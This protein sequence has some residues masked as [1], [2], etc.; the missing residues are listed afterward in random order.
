M[1]G[2]GLTRRSTRMWVQVAFVVVALA[3]SWA[4][5]VDNPLGDDWEGR[6]L[7]RFALQTHNFWSDGAVASSFATSLDPYRPGFNYAHHPPLTNGLMTVATGV[8]GVGPWQ[9]RLVP[10]LAAA[11]S[12]ILLAAVLRR[13]AVRE[14]LVGPTVLFVAALPLFWSF[15]RAGL[16][17]APL[18]A[19]VWLLALPPEAQRRWSG[20][21]ALVGVLAS[22]AGALSVLGAMIVM[23]RARSPAFRALAIGAF[24]GAAITA[25]WILNATSMTELLGHAATRTLGGVF[26][27]SDF[28]RQQLAFTVGGMTVIGLLVAIPATAYAFART[29]AREPLLIITVAATIVLTAL[30]QAAFSRSFLALPFVAVFGI[31]VGVSAEAI[32]RRVDGRAR[33]LGGVLTLAS[34]MMFFTFILTAR[35]YTLSA[36]ASDAGFLLEDV[37]KPPDVELLYIDEAIIAPRWAAWLWDVEVAAPD[38][39]PHEGAVILTS[40]AER[41]P[42]IGEAVVIAVRGD[43]L[44]LRVGH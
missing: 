16:G 38:G 35:P 33:L 21:I 25:I 28:T 10:M 24:M 34:V 13:F 18:L 14:T 43:Y 6:L 36:E 20:P 9:L 4:P 32:A 5:I 31:S 12:L 37:D 39:S 30:N 11:V 17:I 29:P 2:E 3:A 44:L 7:G 22:W 19:V 27:F 26:A 41:P 8:F 1:Q 15:A 42:W 23:I 40:T